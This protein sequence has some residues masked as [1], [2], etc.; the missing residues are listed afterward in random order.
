MVEQKKCK[1]Q[2][3]RCKVATF[4]RTSY[5]AHCP[6]NVHTHARS[7]LKAMRRFTVPGIVLLATLAACTRHGEF[8]PEEVLRRA[9]Q[10]VNQLQSAAFTVTGQYDSA[11]STSLQWSAKGV[12]ADGG[13]QLSFG[14]DVSGTL[15]DDQK[16]KHALKS[17][18]D[19]V[20][21]GSDVF[22][23]LQSLS[24]VPPHPA[25]RAD[26][27][28]SIVGTWYKLPGSSE[29]SPSASVTPDPGLLRAQAQVISVIEDRG[30]A[31]VQGHDAYSYVVQANPQKLKQFLEASSGNASQQSGSSPLV[32]L[33]GGL[34]GEM[35]INSTTFFVDRFR[36]SSTG[37]NADAARMSLDMVLTDHNKAAPVIPPQGAIPFDPSVIH[38][39]PA[40]LPSSDDQ[41]GS[42]P[43]L[44]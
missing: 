30:L 21:A 15:T 17:H 3:A 8:P 34:K 39:N 24:V 44:P 19:V 26:E 14:V 16:Q 18:A 23:R 33:L 35:L 10:A 37:T 25:I 29:P 31:T 1:E 42:F 5:F 36:W 12:L 4:V 38:A 11:S 32:S 22:F 9:A 13:K 28:A 43:L 6:S 20:V 2:G 7:L 27:A 41:G 40:D